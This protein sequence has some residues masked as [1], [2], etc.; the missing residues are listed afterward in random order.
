MMSFKLFKYLARTPLSTSLRVKFPFTTTPNPEAPSQ[1]G[2]KENPPKIQKVSEKA[3][4]KSAQFKKTQKTEVKKE[5]EIPEALQFS[6]TSEITLE[7]LRKMKQRFAITKDHYRVDLGLVIDRPPIFLHFSDQEMENLKYRNTLDKKYK[8]FPSVPPE[9]I[10]F[11]MDRTGANLNISHIQENLKTHS[12]KLE[13]GSEEYYCEHSKLYF[14]VDPNVQTPKSI[15][16]SPNYKVYLLVKNKGNGEW[17]FPSFYVLE[18]E[19]FAEARAKYFGFLSNN[20][21]SVYHYPIEPFVFKKREFTNEEK[22]D[23]RNKRLKGVKIFYF[24][25]SHLEGVIEINPKLYSDHAWV[26]KLEMNQYLTRENY[27]TFIHSLVSY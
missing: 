5:E 10:D 24:A 14:Q 3:S 12:R 16:R 21:W 17:E 25:A 9:L 23:P 26:S 18:S 4:K 1:E 6:K 11:Q 22:Q 8:T 2:E 27:F 13:D 20:N 7:K 19:K 15:Q